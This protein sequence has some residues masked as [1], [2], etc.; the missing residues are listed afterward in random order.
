MDATAYFQSFEDSFWQWEEN[1]EVLA[2]PGGTTIAYKQ[3]L[4]DVFPVISPQGLPPFG[5]LLLVIL[6][7]NENGKDAIKLVENIISKEGN[8]NSDSNSVTDFLLLLADLPLD[9]RKGRN[10]LLLIQAIFENCHYK[11][12]ARKS[13]EIGVL[14]EYGEISN[15]KGKLPFDLNVIQKDIRVLEVIAGKLKSKEAILEKIAG[16]PDLPEELQLDESNFSPQKKGVSDDF[17][18][19][20]IAQEKTFHVGSLVRHLWSGL[21]IPVH[22]S[23]PSSQPLGGVSD[24]SNKGDFDKLLISEFANDDLV[25][26]S[27]LANNEALYIQREIPPSQNKFERHILI[28]A[29]LKNWGTPKTLAFAIMLAIARHPKTDFECRCFIIGESYQE[30]AI[31][32]LNAIIQS[33]DL[34]DANLNAAIGFSSFLRDNPPGSDKEIFLITEKSNLKQASMLKA[35]NEFHHLV[36]YW[37]YTD[38]EGNIDLYK[39]QQGSKRHI[40]HILLPLEE[41]WSKR[42]KEKAEEKEDF[43]GNYPILFHAPDVSDA[44]F[45]TLGVNCY[46]ISNDRKV[47]SFADQFVETSFKESAR[48]KGW[49]LITEKLPFYGQYVIGRNKRAHHI[50]AIYNAS[51]NKGFLLN[52]MNKEENTFVLDANGVSAGKFF[53]FEGKFHFYCANGNWIIDAETGIVSKDTNALEKTKV[54]QIELQRREVWNKL[55]GFHVNRSILKNIWT[56]T[57]NDQKRL[58]FGNHE[59]QLKSSNH[60][61]LVSSK[62][63]DVLVKAEINENNS[64]VF[65]DGSQCIVNRSGMIILRSSNPKMRDIFIPSTLDYSLGVAAGNEFSGNEYYMKTASKKILE[66]VFFEKYINPFIQT[67][68]DYGT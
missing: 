32:H 60:I 59:L 5:A 26:L 47:Y 33:Q 4:R 7:T 30:V 61:K 64:F 37:I 57:I 41:L 46:L 43:K 19:L 28:D 63:E 68:L 42:P 23:V 50:L 58:S 15:A 13:I 38:A 65:P 6:A 39:R 56:V 17:V 27:R 45:L 1:G 16:L 40:Q 44:N 9:M 52:L 66:K 34:L 22:S 12:A 3:F 29:T 2:I 24:L 54:D 21:N 55:A 25:F 20:L 8:Y 51:S 35:L 11:M 49:V 10:R 48:K 36:N 53:F 31:D 18:D 67:I 62:D 14:M